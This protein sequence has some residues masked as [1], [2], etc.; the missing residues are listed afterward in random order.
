MI[1]PLR[2]RYIGMNYKQLRRKANR[3]LVQAQGHDRLEEFT[4]DCKGAEG[5]RAKN[6]ETTFSGCG[7]FPVTIN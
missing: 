7:K 3:Y 1:A 2:I 4:W 5:S 6:R